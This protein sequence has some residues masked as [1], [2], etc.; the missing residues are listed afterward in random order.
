MIHSVICG[1]LLYDRVRV[2]SLAKNVA[3]QGM[4]SNLLQKIIPRVAKSLSVFVLTDL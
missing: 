1:L 4:F 3:R 2:D